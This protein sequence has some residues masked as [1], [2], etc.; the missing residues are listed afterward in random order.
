MQRL[1]A[2]AVGVLCTSTALAQFPQL[3]TSFEQDSAG[4]AYPFQPGSTGD[5]QVVLF[6]DPA[7][8]DVT[9]ANVVA[10]AAATVPASG[11]ILPSS[12]ESFVTNFSGD[13]FFGANGTNQ[14]LDIRFEW[15]N[16][17]PNRW[18][19]VETLQSPTLGDPSVHLGGKVRFYVN[20]PDCSA[21]EFPA[22][23]RTPEIGVALLIS[24]TGSDLPQGF[25]DNAVLGGAFEFVGVSS[26]LDP[27]TLSPTPVP[28]TFVPIT[29][30]DCSGSTTGPTADWRLVEID[31]A[32]ANVIGWTA[33]GG[34]GILDAT[35]VGDGVNRGT[36]A[37]IVLAV[38]GTDTTS[39]YVEF[40][41]D[42]ITFEAP[43]TEPA[44]APAILGPLVQGDTNV[45]IDQVT[46]RATSV[47]LEIDRFD[48]NDPGDNDPLDPNVF[49]V[50]D[51]LT[52][53]PGLSTTG[54]L[55]STTFTVGALN[56]GDRLRARQAVG[57]DVS[58]DS[59]I[60][61]VNPPAAFSA[62]LSL[63]EDGTLGTAA[64]FEWVGATSVVGS[65]GT[66][67][68]PV[69]A[70][71]G[72]WQRLE[73]SLIPG[74]EPVI[75]FA[76]GDGQLAPNGGLY[77]ID[78]M[79]FTIDSADPQTGPY[80]IFLDEVY[81]VNANGD[82]ITIADAESFN[83]FPSVRGQSTS[84]NTSSILSGLASYQG[85]LSNR[86]G[87]TFPNL[88]PSNTHAPFRPAVTFPDSAQAVGMWLLVEDPR[89]ANLP[90]P[91]VEN[92]IIGAAPAVN[93]TN[94]DPAATQLDLLVN[95]AVVASVNPGG[96]AAV[97][98]NPGVA[99]AI[100]DSVSAQSVTA[101]IPSNFAFARGVTAPAAPAVQGPL[102]ETQTSITVTGLLNATNATASLVTLYIDGTP[103]ATEDPLGQTSVTF[104]V[105]PGLV[106]GEQVAASQTV[107]SVESA[108][109][110]PVGVGTGENDLCRD[111]R[112]PVRRLG[113]R[114]SRVRRD[115]QQR[116]RPD[117]HLGLDAAGVGRG[118][119]A[120]RC[121]AGLH[122][123]GGD[124]PRLGRLLRGWRRNGSERRS[125]GRHDEPV[126][127]RPARDRTARRER[128]SG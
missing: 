110:A 18:V 43:V 39:Q 26:V 37:G 115:L 89:D 62:T 2:V 14:F 84:I 94:I 103:V 49:I 70:Q 86:L 107:N 58:A 61:L 8:A 19:L 16:Q 124:D 119:P 105:N 7:E 73:F 46:P 68:K 27:N 5:L 10:D 71:N 6:Q 100:G 4:V 53:P 52:Q 45:S 106:A 80:D 15:A 54:E 127:Q 81:Y 96:A 66:Q 23:S 13:F 97:N 117:R 29:D 20:I 88:D 104:T 98:V 9:T 36:L 41:I 83:P 91:T 1:L 92:P 77:N 79:F 102:V 33:R 82:E 34:D 12:E 60:V 109:S 40:L 72:V 21:F 95:G 114:R 112:G 67:G 44:V 122:D 31:L 75:S 87:W 24:E 99:L 126:G 64:V 116:S 65:A 48:P 123:P 25:Q 113:H 120:G 30:L 59:L 118:W 63:D 90:Q 93:V 56:P 51:T 76:G 38:R 11:S 111:Q 28:S 128:R 85:N 22:L 3:I 42:E 47:T 108:L 35:G 69:F 78:A 55:R 32:T 121:A 50:T 125:C 17:D 57:A 101:G 74:V